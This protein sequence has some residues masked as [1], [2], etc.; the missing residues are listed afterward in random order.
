MPQVTGGI[1]QADYNQ[2]YYNDTL[3]G[4]I[5]FRSLSNINWVFGGYGSNQNSTMRINNTQTSINASNVVIPGNVGIGSSSTPTSSLQVLGMT[6]TSSLTTNQIY[7]QSNVLAI[8][9]DPATT[10]INIGQ[11]NGTVN[12]ASS[13]L[14]ITN[15][16]ITLNRGGAASS[17]GNTGILIEE[18]GAVTGYIQTSAD[19]SSFIM[20]TPNATS[21]TIFNMASNSLDINN[22]AIFVSSNNRIAI[23]HTSPQYVLDVNGSINANTNIYASSNILINTTQV[24]EK[25]TINSG[26][27]ALVQSGTYGGSN[28]TDKWLA[29]GDTSISSA[30]LKQ[31]S[32]YGLS[33][34]WSNQGCFMGLRSD[35]SQNYTTVSTTN[36]V[37][38][39]TSSNTDLMVLTKTGKLGIANT[40]PNYTLDVTGQANI[41]GMLN[42]N[43]SN[44]TITTASQP[45]H[46]LIDSSSSS[47][48]NTV[49]IQNTSG[50]VN[51]LT[52]VNSNLQG[53]QT[54]MVI[55]STG[56]VGVGTASPQAPLHILSPNTLGSNVNSKVVNTV[57]QTNDSN[58]TQLQFQSVRVYQGTSHTTDENRIQRNVDTSNQGYIGMSTAAATTVGYNNTEFVRVTST[59]SV[60]VGTSNPAA[61]VDVIG[62][63]QSINFQG[64]NAAF[65]NTTITTLTTNN[66][67]SSNTTITTLTAQTTNLSNLTIVSSA[68][69]PTIVSS[70]FLSSN[71]GV[72][73]S[74]P[75]P[76]YSVDVAGNVNACNVSINGQTLHVNYWLSNSSNTYTMSNVGIGTDSPISTLHVSGDIALDCNLYMTKNVAV[77]GLNIKPSFG[78]MTNV[79]L[80]VTAVPGF[81]FNCNIFIQSFSN[82]PIQ[83]NT[84]ANERLRIDGATGNIGIGN[85]SPPSRLSIADN[86]GTT[87]SNSYGLL[88]ISQNSNGAAGTGR[89]NQA[90]VSLSRFGKWVCGVGFIRQSNI[91]GFGDA[92]LSNQDFVPNY[93]SI[94][95]GGNV[96]I[97]T[98]NPSYGLDVTGT[99]HFTSNLTV[100][101]SIVFQNNTAGNRI[102]LNS[103]DSPAAYHGLGIGS[104]SMLVSVPTSNHSIQFGYTSNS[105]FNDIIHMKASGY[106]GVGVSNPLYA[107]DVNGA[108]KA[109]SNVILGTSSSNAPTGTGGVSLSNYQYNQVY[110]G[111]LGGTNVSSYSVSGIGSASTGTVYR[112]IGSISSESNTSNAGGFHME[113]I[114]GGSTSAQTCYLRADIATRGVSGGRKYATLTGVMPSSNVR[115]FTV[116]NTS[117]SNYDLYVKYGGT[118][119]GFQL[120]I[121]STW[122]AFAFV[123]TESTTDPTA[124]YSVAW[125]VLPSANMFMSSSNNFIGVNTVSPLYTL[126]VNGSINTNQAVFVGSN[127]VVGQSNPSSNPAFTLD[128]T[129][130]SRFIGKQSTYVDA[131][132]STTMGTAGVTMY[133]GAGDRGLGIG[134]SITSSNSNYS[135]LQTYSNSPLL[136]NPLAGNVGVNTSNPAYPL[137]VNGAS[138]FVGQHSIYVDAVASTT[139]GT[140]GVSIYNAAGNKGLGIGTGISS[141]NYAFLQTYSNTPLLL[142]PQTGNVGI[143]T[144]NPSYPLDV[145][146]QVRFRS[147]VL[148]TSA[149]GVRAVQ[150]LYGA[151]IRNDGNDLY[152]LNTACNDVYGSWNNNRPF[153]VNLASGDTYL[154]NYSIYVSG[155]TSNVG[156]NTQSP[157]YQLDVSGTSR[158][159][160]N[161]TL[162]N[163][164]IG[165]AGFGSNTAILANTSKFDQFSYAIMHTSAGQ[166]SINTATGT[167][168]GFKNNNTSIGAWST[169]GLGIGTASPQFSLD[170]LGSINATSNIQITNTTVAYNTGSYVYTSSS[171]V[172]YTSNVANAQSGKYS[173]AGCLNLQAQTLVNSGPSNLPGAQIFLEGGKS[174]NGVASAGHV[175][176]KTNNAE[177]VRVDDSGNVGIGTS[178]PAYNLDVNGSVN[179]T[180]LYVGGTAIGSLY[181]SVSSVTTAQNT[182]NSAASSASTAQSAANTAQS[183]ANSAQST[184]NSAA[185]AANN[186]Q[187]TA[188][189][190][191]NNANGRLS[192]GGGRV[193]GYIGV[194]VN[195]SYPIDIGNAVGFN[196]TSGY[197]FDSQGTHSVSSSIGLTTSLRSYGGIQINNFGLSCTSDKRIKHD[198]RK[199][200]TSNCI[201][202]IEQLNVVNYKYKDKQ[203]ST[204]EQTG[205]IAQEVEPVFPI[206]VRKTT[207]RIPS[208]QQTYTVNR[209]DTNNRLIVLATPISNIQ[210]GKLVNVV[211]FHGNQWE[212]ICMSESVLQLKQDNDVSEVALSPENQLFIFGEVVDDLM[213]IEKDAIFC[214]AVGA[215][216]EQQKQIDALTT[217]LAEIKAL[218]RSLTT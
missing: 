118:N 17:A 146:G 152:I 186:A 213:S 215:I 15:K 99:G 14:T 176:M 97:A 211:D 182:A 202:M 2:E 89:S 109:S 50:A 37:H 206:A 95:Q 112:L 171:T 114:I 194:N 205:F 13:N 207:G 58:S 66:T 172:G 201:H 33:V 132:V 151:F 157:Q 12:I 170:V 122:S 101:T 67:T 161:T 180:S 38:F 136:L 63:T 32:N 21:N 81:S 3:L 121:K 130:S 36:D 192:T 18:A 116:N 91:L 71:I 168:I 11:S 159:T 43:A 108:I 123:N 51:F 57:F 179:A 117:T 208:I 23:N 1:Q 141:C 111:S 72:N 22:H 48:S 139:M 82:Y 143:N 191:N 28:G 53:G 181:A 149:N 27:I 29:V 173:V 61:T 47:T 175:V 39:Q 174:P 197:Y 103:N 212:C 135:F 87:D 42:L 100:D 69:I 8:G 196:Q 52:G 190:A 60:G 96:G 90:A 199:V 105:V 19:R 59:G 75:N 166:T 25:L 217:E 164:N 129:G 218:L 177:R 165:D 56:Q 137:D 80:M 216:Q 65:S 133:N 74:N 86:D 41:T 204:T 125:D 184:A 79:S 24:Q 162:N 154:G 49:L 195:A 127:I 35:G 156:I 93:L 150:G 94:K 6:S 16:V 214:I 98:P 138:R 167:S 178:T 160:G 144:S 119:T 92:T 7:A 78:G 203:F 34:V 10:T 104:S 134:T 198:I 107:L 106:L 4:D 77:G 163:M 128:V 185:S 113:G 76:L 148:C 73:T 169:T 189:S 153:R 193:N 46:Q 188:D 115:V 126:D 9:T 102:T 5:V 200:C 26:N 187:S 54:T 120:D 183:T 147:D 44:A 131:T 45:Y 142:N 84:G 124:S 70:N 158:I 40:S 140:A 30:P 55:A 62:T 88:Q 85:S 68:T 209:R 83:F 110:T 31:L 64:S 145:N 210:T 20:R 155:T